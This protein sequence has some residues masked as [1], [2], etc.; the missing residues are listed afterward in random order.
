M[1]GL[2]S[3]LS[4]LDESAVFAL[5]ETGAFFFTPGL[6]CGRNLADYSMGN[7]RVALS[8][9]TLP[10]DDYP[11]VQ[12]AIGEIISIDPAFRICG[13]ASDGLEAV[14]MVFALKPGLIIMDIN[15]PRRSGIEAAREIRR[16]NEEAKILFYSGHP[17][18]AEAALAAGGDGFVT[19]AAP[20]FTFKLAMQAVLQGGIYVDEVPWANLRRRFSSPDIAARSFT[21]EQSAV[22]PLLMQGLTSK[23]IAAKLAKTARRVDKVRAQL[24]LQLD[25][26]NATALVLKLSGCLSGETLI[27][28]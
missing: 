25:A 28:K 5:C 8:C 27:S 14:E 15:M 12:R 23:E 1:R 4:N 16:F 19:K 13:T 11:T 10:A 22:A 2:L 9:R 20:S 24:M 6:S 18:F 3:S 7:K 17:E 21:A 26:R